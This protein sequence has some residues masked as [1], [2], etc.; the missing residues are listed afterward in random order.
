LTIGSPLI[1]K[2]R[3]TYDV[4]YTHP[5]GGRFEVEVTVSASTA[6]QGRKRAKRVVKEVIAG[7]FKIDVDDAPRRIEAP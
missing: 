3:L 5:D 1:S 4:S 2:P 7:A 6:G